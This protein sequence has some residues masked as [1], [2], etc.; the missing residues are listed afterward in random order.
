VNYDWYS[1]VP[2]DKPVTQGDI[3]FNCP[4]V[5]VSEKQESPYIEANL[6][7]LK[8]GIVMTQ[9][10]DL[11]HGKVD[12]LTVCELV[13][14]IDSLNASSNLRYQKDFNEINKQRKESIVKE[15]KQGHLLNHHLLDKFQSESM[16]LLY[17]TVSLKEAFT[18]PVGTVNKMLSE[19]GGERLRLLP[20]Y[21]EQLG[22]A[23]ARVFMRV[24]YP[25]DL[26]ID[27]TDI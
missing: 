27:V 18:V 26:E 25:I 11:E 1:L 14:F 6:V 10:C 8:Y 2:N 13:P 20:P 21:R 3:I 15:F 4:V 17:H 7:R 24:G 12:N 9:A 5:E 22:Q 19:Q 16:E 23:Y